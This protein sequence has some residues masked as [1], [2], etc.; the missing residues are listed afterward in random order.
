M[1]K[2]GSVY[3]IPLGAR[4]MVTHLNRWLT[5]AGDLSLAQNVTFENDMVQKEPAAAHYDTV[6]L[7]IESPNGTFSGLTDSTFGAIWLPASASTTFSSV[8]FTVA[9]TTSPWT[10]SV[11]GTAPAGRL[12]AVAVGQR[13]NNTDTPIL[14]SLTDS[15]GNTYARQKQTVGSASVSSNVEIWTSILTTQ[16]TSGVDTLTLTFTTATADDRAVVATTYTGVT[17]ATTEAVAAAAFDNVAVFSSSSNPYVGRSYPALLIAFVHWPQTSATTATWAGG[18]TQNAI[19][20]SG[21]I[22]SQLSVA[23][24]LVVFSTAIVAQIDW[25][26][27][28]AS[29]PAG[30][31]TTTNNSNIVTG[32][33]TSFSSVFVPGD[34]IVAGG[35]TEIVDHVTSNTQ[36][37]TLSTWVTTQ[38]GAAITR[39]SG[40]RVITAALS[41]N[42]F[43]DLPFQG[44][45]TGDLDSVTLASGLST[46]RHRGKFVPAGKENSGQLRKLFYFNGVDPVQMISGDAGSAVVLAG[47]PADWTGSD[48]TKQPVNGIVHQGALFGFGNLNDPH[49]IYRSQTADHTQ[50]TGG[51]SGQYPIASSIGERLYGAAQY[52]GVLFLWK[53]PRGIFYFDDT[54][55]NFLNW[56]YHIRSE[57]L[58]CAPSPH[59]VLP[60]DEDVLFCNS[61]GHFHLLSAVDSLGGQ[62]ASDLTRTYGLHDWMRDN[63]N[64]QALDQ[65]TSA[66]DPA[67]KIASFGCRSLAATSPDNDLLL[68]WDFGQV[69]RGGVPRFSYSNL[70]KPNALSIKRRNYT[71]RPALM[72]GETSTSFFVDPFN[73]GYRS[74]FGVL[75]GVPQTITVTGYD[76]SDQDPAMKNRR[77]HYRALELVFGAESEVLSIPVSVQVALDGVNRGPAVQ[78]IGQGQRMV[79]TLK[80]GDGYEF[81]ATV[82]IPSTSQQDIQQIGLNVYYVPGGHDQSRRR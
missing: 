65:L 63:V 51:D 30:T 39:R 11:I 38:A 33:G 53:Y 76:F 77:K 19:A 16:L 69:L 75:Q 1:A 58:G 20:S 62:R 60:I 55:P 13:I 74:V 46:T 32:A 47:P 78:F 26:A 31:V 54:D 56:S 73:Y 70:W 18:F 40:P 14:T 9:S 2:Q 29:T 71:D 17:G 7:A 50:F 82:T 72:I 3:T 45:N 41:G 59:A 52:Q 81:G 42:L 80:V 12:V 28:A 43:K 67:T 23:S 22:T 10:V 8:A 24:K 57:A 64:T 15:K 79:Q 36:L 68:R 27:D 34:E 61:D 4:G 6:G 37:E 21:V 35:E 25:K 66:W 49:R 44:G 5:T 48:G